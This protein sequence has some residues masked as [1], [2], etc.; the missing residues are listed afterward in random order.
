MKI[1]NYLLIALFVT[2]GACKQPPIEFA[3]FDAFVDFD[4]FMPVKVQETDVLMPDGSLNPEISIMEN[5]AIDPDV[6]EGMQRIASTTSAAMAS[7]ILGTLNCNKVKQIAGT[8]TGHD[9]DGSPL[10]LSGKVVVPSSGEVKNIIVVSH[11]TIGAA[12]EAPSECFPFE[13][14]LAAK[15]YA[16][17]IADYI[18]YGVTSHMIHPY[19]HARS[20]SRS[21]VDFVRA[22]RPYLEHIG[23][24][25][26]HDELILMGY[27]Q[28]GATTLAVMRMMENDF[29][30]EFKIKKVYAGAGPYDLNATFDISM[31]QN[32][33]GIPCAIP[34]IVQGIS[35]GERLNLDMADFFQ[36]ALLASYEELINS[37][38]Y[39]VRDINRKINAN[40]LSDIMTSEGRNKNSEQTARLYL[41]LFHNSVLNFEPKAPLYMFHSKTDD[42]VPFINSLKAEERF[43]KL[44][45]DFDFDDY[46]NHM[47]GFLKFL[48][49]VRK[50]L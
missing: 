24:K 27:S 17:V 20:T 16:V 15:G 9:V 1:Y 34:M 49:A 50:D 43:K 5:P 44:N 31:E 14:T 11:Y 22:V 21:V 10:T 7:D 47:Q 41:A 2:L 37:K 12:H 33:T 18:G 13:G 48:K 46:G 30:G 40:K 6:P 4:D 28:G 8:Y 3:D 32:K 23:K 19:L 25:P 26:K 36:P 38:K 35:L 45:V 29:E 39:T 42:T